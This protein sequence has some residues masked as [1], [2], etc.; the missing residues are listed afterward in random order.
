MNRGKEKLCFNLKAR[1]Y[2][3]EADEIHLT[4]IIHN[5]L[6]NANKYSQGAPEIKIETRDVENGIA[7]IISDKGL[8]MTREQL[9][10]IFDKFYRVPTGN[11]HNVKGF[12]LGL[13]YVKNMVGLHKGNIKVQSQP[14][15]GSSFEIFFPSTQTIKLN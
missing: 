14:G 12:G 6:D 3:I 15:K 4:N 9:N 10:K 5:L 7:F 13:S 2:F 11:I 1:H 8:G